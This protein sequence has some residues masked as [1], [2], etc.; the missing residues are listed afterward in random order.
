[1]AQ[2]NITIAGLSYFAFTVS[3]VQRLEATIPKKIM[4]HVE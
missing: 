4:D 1:M 2:L 3:F